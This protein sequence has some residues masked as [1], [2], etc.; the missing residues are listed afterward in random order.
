MEELTKHWAIQLFSLL[1][2]FINNERFRL[3]AGEDE[4]ERGFCIRIGAGLLL[5]QNES[6]RAISVTYFNYVIYL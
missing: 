5:T 3:C 1:Y 2:V 4:G 6:A